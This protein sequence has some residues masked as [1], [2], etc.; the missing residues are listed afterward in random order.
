MMVIVPAQNSRRWSLWIP[1]P[2]GTK[3][4][5]VSARASDAPVRIRSQNLQ[6]IK[7]QALILMQGVRFGD[8]M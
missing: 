8:Q 2:Q 5:F 4:G 6:R 1:V 7:Y 3:S